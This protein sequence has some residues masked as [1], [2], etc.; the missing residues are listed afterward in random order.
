MDSGLREPLFSTRLAARM[1]GIGT[2]SLKSYT[3]E[4]LIQPRRIGSQYAYSFEDIQQAATI[5]NLLEKWG[6]NLD[7]VRLCLTIQIPLQEALNLIPDKDHPVA[8][9]ISALLGMV[10]HT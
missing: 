5:A 7:G 2:S 8:K 3:K 9:E 1:A 6:A 4:Q 10:G